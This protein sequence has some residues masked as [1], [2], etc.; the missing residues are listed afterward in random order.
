[1]KRD[2]VGRD[3]GVVAILR[4]NLANNLEVTVNN[5][6]QLNLTIAE[7]GADAERVDEL[8]RRLMRDLRELGAESVERPT[9]GPTL[10][11]AKAAD[12]FTWGALT[13]AAAPTFL[14][15][16]VQ[17]LQAWTLRGEKRTV[18]IKTPAGMEI[19]F[20][21]EERLSQD[22]IVALVEKLAQAQGE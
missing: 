15:Q 7:P 11:G 18:K 2:C 17:F 9:D 13:L 4:E 14:P 10:E 5:D 20:T 6:V 12:A 19:E 3:T 16:L 22:E 1:V 21:P 8:T